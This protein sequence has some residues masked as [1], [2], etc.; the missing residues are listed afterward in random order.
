MKKRIEKKSVCIISNGYPTKDDPV[1][2][3][4]QPLVKEIADN[5]FLC[6]VIAPQSRSNQIFSHKNKR[7]YKWIDKTDKGNE[8]TIFQPQYISVSKLKVKN[9]SISV[10]LRDQAI[11]KCIEKEKIQTDI[12]YAHF[13]DCG[14]VAGKIA[15]KKKIP[16]Y[17]ATGESKIRVFDYYPKDIIDKY[18]KFIN[19]VICVSTKNLNESQNLKLIEKDKK[20]I[21]LPNAFNPNEFYPLSKNKVRE[22]LGFSKDSKIAIFVG[23]FSERKGVLR[24]VEAAKEIKGLKLVLIG[25]GKLKPE[26]NQILFCGKMPHNQIVEYLNSADVFVLPTLA[27]GCCNAIVEALACGLPVISSDL[28]FNKDILNCNNSIMINPENINEISEALKKIV[29]SD[30]LMK[31]MSE[32]ALLMANSLTIKNRSLKICEFMNLKH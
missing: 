18:K 17:V 6:T 30:I 12:L 9:Q 32:A 16:V 5:G 27:E 13:W 24:V 14:I 26:S 22:K 7:A 19:G 15:E 1:Y 21:I 2:A 4:I 28:P 20:V 25:E 8:I 11:I 3:F 29:S 10:L 23:A 31:S